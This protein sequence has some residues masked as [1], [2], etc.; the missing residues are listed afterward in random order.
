M[1]IMH[2]LRSRDAVWGFN[3]GQYKRRGRGFF[4]FNVVALFVCLVV[5]YVVCLL[6]LLVAVRLSVCRPGVVGIVFILTTYSL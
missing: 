1:Y 6:L 2:K 4:A 3:N 5:C